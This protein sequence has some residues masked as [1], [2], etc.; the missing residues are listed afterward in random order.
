MSVLGRIGLLGP[1]RKIAQMSYEGTC[2]VCL[3]REALRVH[4]TTSGELFRCIG[5]AGCLIVD[6]RAAL[7][8]E[9]AA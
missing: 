2:P 7:D 9:Q 6:V 3:E 1:V 8:Q 5:P 4:V